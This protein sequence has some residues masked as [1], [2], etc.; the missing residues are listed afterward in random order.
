M[1]QTL[2]F[3][4]DA[5]GVNN[6]D[7]NE[8]TNWWDA[9]G[10]TGGGGL[11]GY[12]PGV[13]DTLYIETPCDQNVPANLPY[14]IITYSSLTLAATTT[15]PTAGILSIA[16]GGGISA[17]SL[18][19]QGT[20]EINGG[21][22]SDG[23]GTITIDQS[24]TIDCA[25]SLWVVQSI[26]VNSGE[27]NCSLNS[28]LTF[29]NSLSNNLQGVITN[30]ATLKFQQTVINNG[31]INNTRQL[32]ITS[33]ATVT[34]NGVLNNSGNLAGL[35]IPTTLALNNNGIFIFGNYSTNFKGRIFPQIPSSA[36][37]GNALL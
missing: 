28:V 19:I 8:V 24:G 9:P 7:W 21:V 27:I 37:W 13:G 32:E 10:G 34:N 36:S 20:L 16:S 30:D 17:I 3:N 6:T 4:D 35:S 12:S 22:I 33:N 1:S 2:Y 15:I 26:V 25:S 23:G 31:T 18:N 11:N 14:Y 29:T 5:G